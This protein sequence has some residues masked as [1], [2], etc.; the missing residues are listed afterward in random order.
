M[1]TLN[2]HEFDT[3]LEELLTTKQA[4]NIFGLTKKCLEKWR[5]DGNGPKFIKISGRCIRYC[6]SHILDFLES[7]L[8]TNTS[9]QEVS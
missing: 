8:R 7:R 9:Q 5:G 1:Y 4:A 2:E 6:P 3:K